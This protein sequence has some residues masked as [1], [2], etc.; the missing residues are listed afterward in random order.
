MVNMARPQWPRIDD[1]DGLAGRTVRLER[2]NAC[3][4]VSCLNITCRYATIPY[5]VLSADPPALFEQ[6]CVDLNSFQNI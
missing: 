1:E 5:L 3:A 6:Y 4:L 2:E